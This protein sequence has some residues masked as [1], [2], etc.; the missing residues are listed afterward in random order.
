MLLSTAVLWLNSQYKQATLHL[1][2]GAFILTRVDPVSS[3]TLFLDPD[4]RKIRI[5]NVNGEGIVTIRLTSAES[6]AAALEPVMDWSFTRRN[7]QEYFY[8]EFYLTGLP[9]GAYCLEYEQTKGWG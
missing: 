6:D 8:R 7:D 4:A 1:E 9:P 5:V 3:D 2:H